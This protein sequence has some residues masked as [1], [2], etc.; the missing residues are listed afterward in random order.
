MCGQKGCPEAENRGTIQYIWCCA[1]L[2]L[3]VQEIKPA[4]LNPAALSLKENSGKSSAEAKTWTYW[5]QHDAWCAVMCE[6]WKGNELLITISNALHN[7]VL[8]CTPVKR[9]LERSLGA[10]DNPVQKWHSWLVSNKRAGV[11]GPFKSLP[12]ASTLWTLHRLR[13]S[14]H[15]SPTVL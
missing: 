1:T 7:S 2:N 13:T 9:R 14:C 10:G 15:C 5:S 12:H 11:N 8:P 6:K 4:P 3:K